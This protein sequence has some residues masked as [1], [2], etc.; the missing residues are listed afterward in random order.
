MEI[1][2]EKIVGVEIF[3]LKK[4]FI[5]KDVDEDEGYVI[6]SLEEI[7]NVISSI[8]AEKEK[9]GLSVSA[10]RKP[11]TEEWKKSETTTPTDF[12]LKKEK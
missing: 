11:L 4:G 12:F 5:L 8:I 7:G 1:S 3:K 10:G 2:G 9:K 6:N